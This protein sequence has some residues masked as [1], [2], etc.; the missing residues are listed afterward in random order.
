[1]KVRTATSNLAAIRLLAAVFF[2]VGLMPVQVLAA[3][4]Y[5]SQSS[6]KDSND[7]KS[8]ATAW[9]TL[10]KASQTYAPGDSILLKCGDAWNEELHPMGEG[11]AANPITI[12]AYGSGPKPL[13]DRQDATG[14]NIDKVCIYLKNTA[15]YKIQGLEF[16]RCG[17]GV[18]VDLDKGVHGKDYLWIEDCSFRDSLYYN[19]T[20][21]YTANIPSDGG[22]GPNYVFDVGVWVQT[23]ETAD[24]ICLSNITIKNC[25]F[26]KVAC[27][28]NVW[29]GNE[30]D[31][32]ARDRHEFRNVVIDNCTAE[33]GRNWQFVLHSTHGGRITNS[34]VHRV[35]AYEGR[36][37]NGVA[38][39]MLFRCEDITIENCEFGF[40]FLPKGSPDG[41]AMDYEGN[42]TN[43]LARNC[44]FH[45]TQGPGFLF[46][47]DASAD[48]PNLGCVFENC[49]FNAR[50]TQPTPRRTFALN[51]RNEATFRNCRFYLG[52][53]DKLDRP[54]GFTFD[55]CVQKDINDPSGPNLAL[56]AKASA[57]S[58]DADSSPANAIDGKAATAWRSATG[59]SAGEWLELDFGAPKTINEFLV[60]ENRD[61]SVSRFAIQAWD[62]AASAWRNC[63]NGA[64]IGTVYKSAVVPVTT[65]K[66]RLVLHATTKGSPAIDE[67]E[68][69]RDQSAAAAF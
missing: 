7:G 45:Q 51:G 32:K 29:S 64:T 26:H 42:C 46:C 53:G 22:T 9:K 2:A 52:K 30:W 8:P 4:Y 27:A 23:R 36:V 16:A 14:N 62:D 10:A 19:C 60:R 20:G 37:P 6:G 56:G 59:K 66:V 31:K 13:I 39:S 11:T 41:Q 18:F 1:M 43:I 63:F 12:A 38:G 15:G 17:R 48:K 44:L 67:F 35:A 24:V 33:D 5:V 28:V 69:Y 3:T 21:W 54:G 55:G 47:V 57:S 65:R 34:W 25:R 61:S 68:V 49:V 40:I 58:S 50:G